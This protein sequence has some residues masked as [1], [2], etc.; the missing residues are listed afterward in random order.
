MDHVAYRE[1]PEKV[2]HWGVKRRSLGPVEPLTSFFQWGTLVFE[3]KVMRVTR[4]YSEDPKWYMYIQAG[5]QPV[6]GPGP[7]GAPCRLPHPEWSRGPH[8]IA[9][10]GVGYPLTPPPPA[11]DGPW[12]IY[13]C[14]CWRSFAVAVCKTFPCCGH[15]ATYDMIRFELYLQLTQHQSWLLVIFSSVYPINQTENWR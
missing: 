7:H 11:L 5:W 2:W 13:N 14:I 1:M 12:Y 4:V 6:W 8:D 3:A 10:P 15:V 9:R